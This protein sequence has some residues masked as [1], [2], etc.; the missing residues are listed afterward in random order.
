MIS[1]EGKTPVSAPNWFLH[2]L[3]ILSAPGSEFR[4]YT[5]VVFSSRVS[6]DGIYNY[7]KLIWGCRSALPQIETKFNSLQSRYRSNPSLAPRE[8]VS[9]RKRPFQIESLLRERGP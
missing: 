5:R 7:R 6:N 8:S 1:K 2:L 3:L 4:F 9:P